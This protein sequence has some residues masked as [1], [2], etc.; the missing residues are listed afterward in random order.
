M[1]KHFHACIKNA[2]FKAFMKLTQ[3]L[4]R[5]R[6]I[7]GHDLR[8]YLSAEWDQRHH[9][10]RQQ[11]GGTCFSEILVKLVL[12][13]YLLVIIN[14]NYQGQ[15]YFPNKSFNQIAALG[16]LHQNFCQLNIY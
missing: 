10:R 11:I 1:F 5:N 8:K 3:S 16:P 15:M 6:E 4:Y 13:C 12:I 7:K 14:N 2:I 9:R